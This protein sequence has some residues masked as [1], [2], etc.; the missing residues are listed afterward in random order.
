MRHQ[1]QFGL[2]LQQVS[3]LFEDMKLGRMGALGPARQWM[4]T[5]EQAH[6]A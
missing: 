3:Q 5:Q 4:S 6:R 2:K 1:C